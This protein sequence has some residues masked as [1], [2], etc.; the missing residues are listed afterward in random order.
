LRIYELADESYVLMTNFSEL[1]AIFSVPRPSGS[2]GERR[3]REALCVW[4]GQHGIPYRTEHFR[5]FPYS[6]ELIGLWLLGSS[7]LLLLTAALRLPWPALLAV[8]IAMTLVIANVV[9]GRPFVVWMIPARGENI[10]VKFGPADAT[11]EL[12][13][14]T[15]YDS[16]TELFDHTIQGRLFRR[17][18]L[19]IGLAAFVIV[20]GALDRAFFPAGSPWAFA[21]QA[22]SILLALPVLIVVGAVGV[23]LLPGRLI[24]Q[25]QGAVDNGA[26]CAIV[27]ALAERLSQ[28]QLTHTRVT[29]ALFGGEE[30]SMQGSLAFVRGRAWP[31]PAAAINLELMGQRGPFVIWQREGNVLTSVP[32]DTGLN[33]Q[34]AGVVAEVTGRAPAMVGGINSDGYS[35]L[36]NGIPACVLGS[37]DPQQ[38]GGGLHRPTDSL[39]RVALER[40]PEAVTILE[41]LV[42]QYDNPHAAG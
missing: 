42:E 18:P 33:Q 9:T 24:E 15:H 11:R 5:L 1:M 30:V 39:G 38:G 31:L 10:L 37:Y 4:L 14:A 35:F 12:V 8:A 19:C 3:T 13:I 26:A 16:K 34:V 22:V 17:L 27:L 29:L 41:R 2:V 23:N 40:L 32:T 6:N 25:S 28:A 7:L 21:M 36:R 20:L